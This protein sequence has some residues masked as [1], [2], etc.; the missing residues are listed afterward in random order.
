L[1]SSG[2]SGEES[3][4]LDASETGNDVFFLTAAQL[5]PQDVDHALDVYDA[6]VCSVSSPCLASPSAPGVACGTADSCRAAS[7]PQPGVFGAP[8]SATFSGA[9]N[10][11]P[12][13]SKPVVKR[14]VV[15]VARRLAVA[16]RKCRAKPKRRRAVCEAG[17][18][19]R[20][21]VGVRARLVRSLSTRKG[22]R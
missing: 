22:N 6:R 8:P 1:L 3:A 20:Y 5:V 10:L 7:S 16:L 19:R 9:G 13:V 18:R 15:S 17:A 14:K 12:G 4:F 11:L 2:T 21:R